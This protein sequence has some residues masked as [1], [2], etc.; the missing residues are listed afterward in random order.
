MLRDA[1]RKELEASKIAAPANCGEGPRSNSSATLVQRGYQKLD[2]QPAKTAIDQ[3]VVETK[4]G[5][6]KP[7][8]VVSDQLKINATSLNAAEQEVSR[9]QGEIAKR[10][11]AV[12]DLDQ[13]RIAALKE[14]DDA[15][16]AS[17]AAKGRE[18]VDLYKKYSDAKKKA[19]DLQ[20]QMDVINGQL[21]PLQKDLEI[22]VGQ[23]QIMQG[24]VAELENES[25]RLDDGWKEV[26]SKIA[27]Q[28]D[29]IAQIA[30]APAPPTTQ[31]SE[32]PSAAGQSITAK[33]TILAAT[34]KDADASLSSA[35]EAIQSAID[36]FKK[37]G[38][39]ANKAGLE[40]S[41]MATDHPALA[42]I[43]KIAHE[44]LSVHGYKLRQATAERVLGELQL[45]EGR[46]SFGADQASRDAHAADGRGE[47]TAS[48]GDRRCVAGQC[49]EGSAD[50]G[51]EQL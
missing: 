10:Q 50:V 11:A 39:D 35:A 42:S 45:T 30:A 34:V 9:I 49:D 47:S 29:L 18:S 51:R 12:N 2:P 28:T 3:K 15:Q 1:D 16:K 24:A 27:A 17:D 40:M 44:S 31:T 5:P 22:A 13:Q 20:S 21:M 25:K 4:G 26:Q 23:Q 8:W 7:T 14:S 19:A 33:A 32:A 37:A 48:Q 6:D 43:V 38:D 36:E 41:E 46:R